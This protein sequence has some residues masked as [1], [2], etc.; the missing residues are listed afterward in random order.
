MAV[1]LDF[2]TQN[3]ANPGHQENEKLARACGMSN[4]ETDWALRADPSHHKGMVV[5][6]IL[7]TVEGAQEIERAF[8]SGL[9]SLYQACDRAALA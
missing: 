9:R 3:A 6:S 8:H 4:V 2:I 1:I 5:L 7:T